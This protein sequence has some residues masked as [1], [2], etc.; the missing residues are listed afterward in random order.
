MA[1]GS[2]V[3]VTNL[4]PDR[5]ERYGLRYEDIGALNARAIY[6][7]L[8]GYGTEGPERDRLGFDYVAFWAKSG[9]MGSL[10]RPEVRQRS[11]GR[12]RATRQLPWR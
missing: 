4:T 7:A 8:T 12:V 10:V 3:V 2:D 1:A 11:S 9:I 5:Q 6:L